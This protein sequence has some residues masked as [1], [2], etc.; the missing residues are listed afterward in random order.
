MIVDFDGKKLKI[1]CIDKILGNIND[2]LNFE[3]GPGTTVSYG[4]AA[5]FRGDF[6]YFGGAAPNKR[7]VRFFIEMGNCINLGEQG[8]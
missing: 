3:Y 6:Y 5:T 4:C 7:Q 2:N 8:N 1:S